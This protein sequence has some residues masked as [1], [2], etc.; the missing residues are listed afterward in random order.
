M[1]KANSTFVVLATLAVAFITAPFAD[2]VQGIGQGVV[3]TGK[4]GLT[5][6]DYQTFNLTSAAG[7]TQTTTGT[8]SGTIAALN[9]TGSGLIATVSTTVTGT[10]GLLDKKSVIKAKVG[11]KELLQL[12]LNTTDKD[13][14]KGQSLVWVSQQGGILG[15]APTQ[16]GGTFYVGAA[17]LKSASPT[18]TIRQFGPGDNTLGVEGGGGV[19]LLT[20]VVAGKKNA[21]ERSA[22]GYA[23]AGVAVRAS[24]NTIKGLI[25]SIAT[26]DFTIFS[27]GSYKETYTQNQATGVINDSTKGQFN[28][29]PTFGNTGRP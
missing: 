21:N 3:V 17:N 15:Q 7:V 2:A 12:I 6:G 20:S 25:A 10:T 11:N 19:D 8:V 27:E 29:K 16:A 26:L 5:K 14:L 18:V 23:T 24:V 28:S 13:K 22:T 9:V 1:K 4:I